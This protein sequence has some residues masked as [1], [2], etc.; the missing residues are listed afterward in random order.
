MSYVDGFLLPL[1]KAK[2]AEYKKMAKAGAKMFLK[3]GALEYR[4]CIGDD[5]SPAF[6]LPF[7]KLMK[8]KED[9]TVI[10]AWVVYKSKAHRDK[11][12]KAIMNDAEMA[13]EME[14]KEMPFDMKKMGYGGF[15][16]LVEAMAK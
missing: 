3:Y 14:G 10:F 13:A 2:L 16:I 1:P 12:N 8:L 15:K 5:L 4:E 6:G 9:E 7:P 11:V